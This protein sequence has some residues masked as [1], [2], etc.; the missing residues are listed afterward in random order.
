MKNTLTVALFSINEIIRKKTFIV[1]N[2]I[3][4]ALILVIANIPNILS[5]AN[6]DLEEVFTDKVLIVDESNVLENSLINL[7]DYNLGLDYEVLNVNISNEE[8]EKK[9][10]DEEYDYV[11]EVNSS[12]NNLNI[13]FTSETGIMNSTS[14][15]LLTVIEGVYSN[16]Q[17]SKLNLTEDELMALNP[18]LNIEN[19]ALDTTLAED[20]EN[21]AAAATIGSFVSLALFFTIYLF[22]YQ[23]SSAVTTEKTSKIVETLLTSTNSKSIILGKTF[24]L[25][26]VGLLQII[27]LTVF[28]LLCAYIFLP[29]DIINVVFE[30]IDVSFSFISVFMIYYLLGYLLFSF[31]FALTGAMVNR[32]EDVQIVNTPVN[33]IL[34]AG[35]YFGYF[36]LMDP[37]SILNKISSYVPLSS[38]FSMPTRYI[39]GLANT[40]DLIISIVILIL[41]IIVVANISIKIYSNAI[42]NNGSKMN[43]KSLITMYKQ[44]DNI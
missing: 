25:G 29:G 15:Y 31:L 16:L 32:I 39:T 34:V 13:T 3:F 22:A 11:L 14:E 6:V 23:V 41:T 33:L 43:L 7:E 37:T 21:G 40:T 4:M 20:T 42:L 24:G 10:N 30:N 26:L 19:V 18:V 27:A 28:G 12:S 9:L 2:L 35:F 36:T 44:K 1:V 17:L 38:P 8:I 5:F